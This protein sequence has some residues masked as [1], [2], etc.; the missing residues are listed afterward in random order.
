[1]SV[2]T[3]NPR[4]VANASGRQWDP[5]AVLKLS[6]DSRCIAWAPTMGRK[7]RN[8]IAQANTHRF[9]MLLADMAAQQPNPEE[10]RPDLE[11]LAYY[12]LC[13]R[14]HRCEVQSMVE[15]WVR[16]LEEAFRGDTGRMDGQVDLTARRIRQRPGFSNSITSVVYDAVHPPNNAT[17]IA[18]SDTE[19]TARAG[20][21][22]QF[23][24][25]QQMLRDAER[26]IEELSARQVANENRP[27]STSHISRVSASIVPSL[28]SSRVSSTASGL[29]GSRPALTTTSSEMR[30]PT[31]ANTRSSPSASSSASS[32]VPSRATS[33]PA[34]SE[35]SPRSTPSTPIPRCTRSH[36]RRLPFDDECPICQDGNLLSQYESSEV[37]WCRSSCGKSLHKTCLEEWRRQSVIFTCPFCRG[38]WDEGSNCDACDVVHVRRRTIEGDCAI[39]CEDL[40]QAEPE[41]GNADLV[42]CRDGCGQSVHRDCF[43]SWREHCV[44]VGS[45]A[46]CVNCRASWRRE[47][48]GC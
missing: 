15:R 33:S 40:K 43:D 27:Q 42:W 8:P 29:R 26:R 13:S 20:I 23:A 11:C 4:V 41:E 9:E 2:Y 6:L 34:V 32:G 48:C 14:N 18:P 46:S 16:S 47:G 3:S 38:D 28:A 17:G 31:A 39:C 35:A 1:M 36:A 21:Q 22:Q 19:A 45:E 30:R 24:A 12:G 10:L 5:E 25:M 37:V 7:C 44:A